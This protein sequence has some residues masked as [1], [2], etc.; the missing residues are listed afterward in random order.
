MTDKSQQKAENKQQQVSDKML[1]AFAA[2]IAGG[3]SVISVLIFMPGIT[4]EVARDF[5]VKEAQRKYNW[6]TDI[7][8]GLGNS[9]EEAR[10]ES[11]F[12]YSFA[13]R[14]KILIFG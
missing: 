12:K 4:K 14:L 13:Q 11:G 6:A 1:Y 8:I 2:R 5:A 7:Q 9:I 10:K 3:N